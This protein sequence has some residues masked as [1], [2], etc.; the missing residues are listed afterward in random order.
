MRVQP[1]PSSQG[2]VLFVKT[3]PPAEL[4]VSVV[5]GLLSLQIGVPATQPVEGSQSSAPLHAIPSS[6]M[7][8]SRPLHDPP[9]QTS[10]V[11]HAFPSSHA[12]ELLA[13]EQPVVGSQASSV[14]AL[15]SLQT[16]RSAVNAQPIAESQLSIVHAFPSLQTTSWDEHPTAGSQVSAVQMS[17]SS[18][19]PGPKAIVLPFGPE[20][21]PDPLSPQQRTRPSQRK[22]QVVLRPALSVLYR[23]TLPLG[24]ETWP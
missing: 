20:T 6:Q 9:P 13:C 18:H 22:A 19:R 21:W 10:P 11:V 3:H 1:L 17:L 15:S 4:Q 5:Q 7:T 8:V 14:H 2:L 12:F 23:S 16:L 24:P